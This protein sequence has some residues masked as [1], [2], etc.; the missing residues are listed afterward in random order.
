MS[1][2]QNCP[3]IICIFAQLI[4]NDIAIIRIKPGGW[5]ISN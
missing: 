1:D 3:P 4:K 5:L 2:K